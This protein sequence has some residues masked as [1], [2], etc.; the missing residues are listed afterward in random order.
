MQ[1]PR[2]LKFYSHRSLGRVTPW[3]NSP[4]ISRTC[5]S[6]GTGI[7][8]WIT[9]MRAA[10]FVYPIAVEPRLDALYVKQKTIWESSVSLQVGEMHLLCSEPLF[11]KISPQTW[12]WIITTGE[13]KWKRV[14][15][16]FIRS[17]LAESFVAVMV[18]HVR[19][20]CHPNHCEQEKKKN[21][22]PSCSHPACPIPNSKAYEKIWNPILQICWMTMVMTAD[23]V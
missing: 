11:S 12:L 2:V 9:V 16:P 20:C 22:L 19:S 1:H 23:S 21:Q 6:T 10:S 3:S 4:S 5:W 13:L 18:C 17:Q 14:T 15:N 7:V 8:S